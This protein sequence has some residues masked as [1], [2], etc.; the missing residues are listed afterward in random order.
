MIG[1]ARLA[2]PAAPCGAPGSPLGFWP[3]PA[4][5]QRPLGQG[6]DLVIFSRKSNLSERRNLWE[7]MEGLQNGKIKPDRTKGGVRYIDAL[8]QGGE[9]PGREIRIAEKF[10]DPDL[11]RDLWLYGGHI[12]HPTRGALWLPEYI[13]SNN[14]SWDT[15]IQERDSEV[16]VSCRGERLKG[17][18]V[19]YKSVELR[20]A[21]IPGYSKEKAKGKSMPCFG[22]GTRAGWDY[23][24]QSDGTLVRHD[25][26]EQYTLF[27]PAG[28]A[29]KV[30]R[31]PRHS[32]KVAWRPT[33]D[34]VVTNYEQARKFA[35]EHVCV[36]GALVCRDANSNEQKKFECLPAPADGTV[37]GAEGGGP[38]LAGI[39]L[40][41][42]GIIG[43]AIALV[44]MVAFR[45][46][47]EAA[48]PA[49]AEGAPW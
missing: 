22:I 26:W 29:E 18:V 3:P 1:R 43:T 46:K 21:Q 28:T 31:R 6:G 34:E 30:D 4:W 48:A 32:L 35:G 7:W 41:T 45:Q 38:K 2:S 44:A 15:M 40:G 42:W 19:G 37:P 39:G 23:T 11:A 16:I 14:K 49:A 33:G 8:A 47:G 17:N 12:A 9:N 10:Y 5:A 24:L 13:F 27:C 25:P 36:G 20:E